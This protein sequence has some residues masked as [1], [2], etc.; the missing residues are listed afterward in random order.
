MMCRVIELSMWKEDF[1]T[2]FYLT[3][4]G[5]E[6]FARGSGRSGCTAACFAGGEE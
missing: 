4:R 3:G 5:S 6:R 1:I 2:L